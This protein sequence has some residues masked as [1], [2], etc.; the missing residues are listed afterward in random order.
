MRDIIIIL[1]FNL[2]FISIA[3]CQ[4]DDNNSN[5]YMLYKKA[6]EQIVNDS[7]FSDYKLNVSS[8]MAQ[9][10]YLFILFNVL[11]QEKNINSID[12][13]MLL[14]KSLNDLDDINNY[15][16]S[17]HCFPF[18]DTLNRINDN[19]TLNKKNI[20]I[21]FSKVY[22]RDNYCEFFVEVWTVEGQMFG[23]V[24]LGGRY[25]LYLFV[26][27]ENGYIIKNYKEFVIN[28]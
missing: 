2:L 12:D 17:A 14:Y 16:S 7:S 25:Y 27:D 18:V 15:E 13:K 28:N 22:S 26:F 1:V 23:N 3:N 20:N 10:S 6:Y 5:Y 24:N 4:C 11:L 9:S 8:K 19:Y 21:R